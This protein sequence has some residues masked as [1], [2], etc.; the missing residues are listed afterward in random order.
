MYR[1]LIADDEALEREGLEWMISCSMPGA[2][3]VI[4]ADNGRTAIQRAE[5][6]RPDIVLMDIKMPGIEGLEALRRIKEI[7]PR[8]KLVLVTA[9]DYFSYAKQALEIGVRDYV[10]KPAKREQMIGLLTSLVQE[11]NEEH[12]RREEEL[13]TTEKLA[14]LEPLAES[15][16][17]MHL[18]RERTAE[19][20]EGD[21][22]ELL[23][24]PSDPSGYALVLALEEAQPHR[25]GG[26]PGLWGSLPENGHTASRKDMYDAVKS[27]CRSRYTCVVSPLVGR[28]LAVFVIRSGGE[29]EESDGPAGAAGKLYG[30][31]NGQFGRQATVGAGRVHHGLAGLR[32]SYAEAC[33]AAVNADGFPLVRVYDGESAG[34]G[35]P[36]TA[37]NP[38]SGHGFPGELELA[39]QRLLS[40]REE[41]T[42]SVLKEAED[43]IGAHFVEEITLEQAAERV[44]LSPHYFSK[45]FKQHRGETFIDYVTRLRIERAKELMK[46]DELSLK[47]VCFEVGYK[48]PN[49]FS[50][51]FRKVTGVSP[52]GYRGR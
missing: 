41:R 42:T 33:T 18:M 11:L 15:E 6:Y 34:G 17:A 36:V 29:T 10:L 49:Y 5:Q 2:F 3:E 37:G 38:A 32:R 46:N 45:M 9:Y 21:L 47:E 23:A 25:S 7:H 16:L 8:M 35:P 30:Y 14:R 13:K 26:S 31:V 50:R 19:T 12:A 20:G 28:H 39:A 52:T 27:W 22:L 40:E 48:D 51:V 1:L 4:H 43:W 44:H 24:L